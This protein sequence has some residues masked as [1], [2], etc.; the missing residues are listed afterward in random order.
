MNGV[1]RKQDELRIKEL[2]TRKFEI[3]MIRVAQAASTCL[4]LRMEERAA[5]GTK[6]MTGRW[7]VIAPDV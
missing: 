7:S 6:E 1:Q 5:L 4:R 3:A 2:G